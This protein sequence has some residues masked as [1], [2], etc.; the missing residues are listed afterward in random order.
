VRS[1]EAVENQNWHQTDEAMSEP[2]KGASVTIRIQAGR[3]QVVANDATIDSLR[4]ILA[5]QP[6]SSKH[7]LINKTGL[8]G[9][10]DWSLRWT[11]DTL[12]GPEAEDKNAEQPSLITSLHEQLGLRLISEKDQ[13]E[14]IAIDHVEI[15]SD[16]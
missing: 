12:R 16:N 11:P 15:P 8:T 1:K 2:E 14:A 10:Y 4:S 3:A 13:I 6:E 9:R 5:S 7:P